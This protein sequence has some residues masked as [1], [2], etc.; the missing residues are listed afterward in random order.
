MLDIQLLRKDLPAVAARI[1][2]RGGTIDWDQFTALEKSRKEI[3]TIVQDTQAAQNKLSKEIGQAKGKGQEV[4][5][6][7]QAAERYKETL[8][9]SEKQLVEIQGRLEAFLLTV[10]NAPHATVP[11]GQ[12]AEQNVEVRRAGEPRKF[13]FAVKDHVDLGANLGMLDFEAATKIAGA[14]FSLMRGPLARLHR[15]IAQFMLDVHT[16]EHGYTEVYVPYLVNAASMRGTG[17]LPKF[18]ETL[19]SC[20]GPMRKSSISSRPRKCR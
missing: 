20:R 7:M 3:Q 16:A 2:E 15:S 19:S 17:Q 4:P 5:E 14:R 9:S 12:S 13:D 6:L 18:E 10:P 11:S 8:A 1:A